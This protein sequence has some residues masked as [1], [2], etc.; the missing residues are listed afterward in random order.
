MKRISSQSGL[1]LTSFIV[2]LFVVGFF[3]Y[4]GMKILPTYNEYHSVVSD[5]EG[6]AAE[7]GADKMSPE[8]IRERLFKRFNLS[9]VASVKPENVKIVKQDGYQLTVAYEVRA[10]LMYNL[11]YV[12]VFNKTVT[13]GGSGGG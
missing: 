12:A 2:V 8:Q 13:V 10:N 9:Y 5:M 7:P 6:L 3:L 11:D 4:I 1:T